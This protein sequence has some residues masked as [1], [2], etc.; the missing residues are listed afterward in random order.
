MTVDTSPEWPEK[1]HFVSGGSDG[2]V[3]EWTIKEVDNEWA[4]KNTHSHEAHAV[5]KEVRNPN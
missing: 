1:R 3:K 5:E 2:K 4:I